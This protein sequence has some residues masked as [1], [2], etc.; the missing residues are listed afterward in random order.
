[1]Q[2]PGMR[3]AQVKIWKLSVC[4]WVER[5]VLSTWWSK[6]AVIDPASGVNLH[7]FL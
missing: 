5:V 2:R 3:R 4:G 1:M 7:N 6:E